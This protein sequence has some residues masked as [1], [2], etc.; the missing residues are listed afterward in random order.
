MATI[1]V[2]HGSIRKASQR[3][4]GIMVGV[5]KETSAECS[6]LKPSRQ[7]RGL[8]R[9]LPLTRQNQLRPLSEQV[10]ASPMRKRLH[11]IPPPK[12]PPPPKN[13]IPHFCLATTACALS[14]HCRLE[15]PQTTTLYSRNRYDINH[16]SLQRRRPPDV[17]RP[18]PFG[19]YP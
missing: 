10:S 2:L 12:I 16:G 4:G 7:Q 15:T 9:L 5:R 6:Q 3:I 14:N 11:R 1:G 19:G 8:T 18:V 17:G 13:N